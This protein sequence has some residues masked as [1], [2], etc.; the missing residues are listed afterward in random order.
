MAYGADFVDLPDW[1]ED[2]L[3]NFIFSMQRRRVRTN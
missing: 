3:C 2:L 1:Q